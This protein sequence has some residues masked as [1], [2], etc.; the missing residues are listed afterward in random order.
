MYVCMYA[1]AQSRRRGRAAPP[2]ERRKYMCICV[3]VYM[4]ICVYVFMGFGSDS[5]VFDV[6]GVLMILQDTKIRC[7]C[8]FVYSVFVVRMSYVRMYICRFDSYH[9]V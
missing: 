4:C 7:I 2:R 5:W 3:Y 9:R 8:V 6:T 1:P